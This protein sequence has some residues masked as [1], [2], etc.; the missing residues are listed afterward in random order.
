MPPLLVRKLALQLSVGRKAIRVELA[1][2]Q[3]GSDRAARLR[4]VL[5][6]AETTT[7]R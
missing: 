3:R 2:R 5:A 4:R 6:I 1:A 7:R